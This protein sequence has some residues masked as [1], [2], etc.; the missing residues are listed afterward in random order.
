MSAIECA[1]CGAV[2]DS[3]GAKLSCARCHDQTLAEI[4]ALR[5][6]LRAAQQLFAEVN[7]EH[8]DPDSTNYNGCEKDPCAWCTEAAAL[9]G[10]EKP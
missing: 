2:S 9:A 10:A 5:K 7:A 8:C 3:G 6:A 1:Y 4:A